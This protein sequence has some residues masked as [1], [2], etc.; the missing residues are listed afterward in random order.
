MEYVG[1][2]DD[3]ITVKLRSGEVGLITRALR[4][5]ACSEQ[6]AIQDALVKARSTKRAK[7]MLHAEDVKQHAQGHIDATL[8]LLEAF[9][10]RGRNPR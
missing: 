9:S 8:A 1:L 10:P 7:D 5:Y 6:Q 2:K 3:L 4:C